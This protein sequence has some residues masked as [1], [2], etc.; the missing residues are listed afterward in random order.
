MLLIQTFFS[1]FIGPLLSVQNRY[2]LIKPLRESALL[3]LPDFRIKRRPV[4]DNRHKT[5]H[6]RPLNAVVDE[7][8]SAVGK[9]QHRRDR[10]RLAT[11]ALNSMDAQIPGPAPVGTA[12]SQRPT[13]ARPKPTES[14]CSQSS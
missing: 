14:G 3:K 2:G 11:T 10:C 4:A 12:D 5:R 7:S 13:G 6:K 1:L 9:R 8:K